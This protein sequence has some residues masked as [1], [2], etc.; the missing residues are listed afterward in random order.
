MT[1]DT[2]IIAAVNTLPDT[3]DGLVAFLESEGMAVP[4]MDIVSSPLVQWIQRHAPDNVGTRVWGVAL[5]GA[6][7]QS[8]VILH[9]GSH[10]MT[11]SDSAAEFQTRWTDLSKPNPWPQLATTW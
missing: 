3:V 6:A 1:T 2:E 10:L 5:V 9:D 11:L 7:G 4:R 8:T